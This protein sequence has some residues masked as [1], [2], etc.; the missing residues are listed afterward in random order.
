MEATKMKAV[1]HQASALKSVLWRILGVI[2][3]AAV[4]YFFTRNWIVT[5][6]ITV[7]HHVFFLFVFYLHE[8]CWTLCKSLTGK[9]R[10]IVKSLLYEIVLGMGFGGLIVYLFTTSF[11]TVTQVT[12]TYTVIRIV[13]YYYYDKA[14]PEFEKN[15]DSE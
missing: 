12:G 1:K 10:N 3:L 4:T 6:K 11:P 14:W 2:T 8:R 7:V 13:S 15:N 9:K 5:T